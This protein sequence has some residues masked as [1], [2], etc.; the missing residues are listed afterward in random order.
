MRAFCFFNTSKGAWKVCPELCDI[1]VPCVVLRFCCEE[2]HRIGAVGVEDIKSNPFFEGVDY[3]H[4]R[5]GLLHG[6]GPLSQA[7]IS[8]MFFILEMLEIGVVSLSRV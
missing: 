4:I 1:N 6:R 5:W 7:D 3:D 8:K 2:E